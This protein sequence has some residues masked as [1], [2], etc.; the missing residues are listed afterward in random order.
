MSRLF[1]ISKRAL[2]DMRPGLEPASQDDAAAESWVK[3]FAEI[4]VR[5]SPSFR[6]RH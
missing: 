2:L 6:N 3:E 5:D 4:L 1:T